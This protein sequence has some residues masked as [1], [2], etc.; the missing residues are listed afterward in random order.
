M[1]EDIIFTTEES[2]KTVCLNDFIEQGDIK[3]NSNDLNNS[4]NCLRNKYIK[5]TN[6]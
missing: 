3:D 6:I 5:M 4:N 2:E 1:K